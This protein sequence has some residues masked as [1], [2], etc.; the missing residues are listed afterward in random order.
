MNAKQ[1]RAVE[2]LAKALKACHAAGLKGG[3]FDNSMRVWPADASPDPYDSGGRFL[4]VI[5]EIGESIRSP[6]SL[7]GGAGV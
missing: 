6:M 7:D 1:K 5:D 2:R 4:E 3:V